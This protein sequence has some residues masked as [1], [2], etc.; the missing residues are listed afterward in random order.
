MPAFDAK[1]L[2][3]AVDAAPTDV[4]MVSE[5]ASQ[6]CKYINDHKQDIPKARRGVYLA[7]VRSHMEQIAE[8]LDSTG[9]SRLAWLFLLEED[10][11]NAW[12][13]AYQGYSKDRYN[14]HCVKILRNLELDGHPAVIDRAGSLPTKKPKRTA[15]KY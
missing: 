15:R 7:S 6:L 12:K 5:V 3:S 2:Q 9:L 8:R 4:D 14:T 10:A 1:S 11:D 13:Y